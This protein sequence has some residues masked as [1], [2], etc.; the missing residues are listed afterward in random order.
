[1]TDRAPRGV[2][3]PGADDQRRAIGP[4]AISSRRARWI[5]GGGDV[6]FGKTEVAVRAAFASPS[7]AARCRLC[8]TTILAEQHWNTF[9]ERYRDFPVRVDGV[10]LEA[11][12]V[13]GWEFGAGKSRLVD[14]PILSTSSRSS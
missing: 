7:T 2:A 8:P 11:A 12:E 14:A 5:A 1:V 6:G 9:R 3:L 10:A 4:C 13:S